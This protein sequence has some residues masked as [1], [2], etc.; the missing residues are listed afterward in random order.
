MNLDKSEKL[1]GHLAKE[2]KKRDLFMCTAESC[3]GG[4]I[5]EL[6][7]SRAGS[8]E[9][10][11]GAVVSY[12]NEMKVNI[13]GVAVETL[14]EHGAVSIPVVQ[15][16]AEGALTACGADCA[17]AASGI[18][19]PDGGS[20]EKPVGTVCIAAA[21]KKSG[22]AAHVTLVDSNSFVFSGNRAA[23]REQAALKALEMLLDLLR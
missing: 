19:G 16:M 21:L 9:W 14:Q 17:V 6:C 23:V 20:A 5:A 1:I 22:E 7:T 11:K 12:S 3:T 18:A 13:L 4:L 15:A 8:S 10:F 2:L